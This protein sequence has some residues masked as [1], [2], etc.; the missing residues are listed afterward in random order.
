MKR[1]LEFDQRQRPQPPTWQQIVDD[2]RSRDIHRAVRA[3]KYLDKAATEANVPELYALLA[4]RDFFFG[5]AVA[6]PLARLEGA[7]ALPQLLRAF[8]QGVDDG[9]DNDGLTATIM[10]LVEREP[11]ESEAVLRELMQSDDE[12]MRENATWALTLVSEG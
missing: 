3:L 1:I 12:H 9:Y 7:R 6:V 11:N 2:L 8:Q 5:E 4:D 10:E